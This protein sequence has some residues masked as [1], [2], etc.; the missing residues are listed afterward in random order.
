MNT[1]KTELEKWL[2]LNT[3]MGKWQDLLPIIKSFLSQNPT[4]YEKRY[5]LKSSLNF[6]LNLL[7]EKNSSY[8]YGKN[9]SG[10]SLQ[11][12]NKQIIDAIEYLHI[13][14]GKRTIIDKLEDIYYLESFP[15][16]QEMLLKHKFPLGRL[17]YRKFK[18][19]KFIE[20]YER[21]IINSRVI[22]LEKSEEIINEF[23][24]LQLP[25]ELWKDGLARKNF[26]LFYSATEMGYE[27]SKQDICETIGQLWSS[28]TKEQLYKIDLFCQSF[29]NSTI[30]INTL[31]PAKNISQALKKFF[32]VY[33]EE[34]PKYSSHGF[35]A[36]DKDE[37]EQ[38]FFNNPAFLYPN[39]E[40]KMERLAAI[41]YLGRPYVREDEKEILQQK[42]NRDKTPEKKKIKI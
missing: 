39:M 35:R 17:E 23:N 5:L 15:M 27:P 40:K 21:N 10:I 19:S 31:A 12:Q 25:L 18:F 3:R 34:P 42:V 29:S 9:N 8:N 36:A 22:F 14:C 33:L 4:D 13:N 37:K 38:I 32:N 26:L 41:R 2:T 6:Y 11:E 1:E 7:S 20:K 16:G 28:C 24:K 30:F